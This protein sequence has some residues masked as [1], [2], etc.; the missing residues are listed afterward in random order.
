M[1]QQLPRKC[2]V[3]GN[4]TELTSMAILKWSQERNVKW[5][6][7]SPG[8]PQQNGFNESFKGRLRDECLNETLLTSPRHAR[9]V[10]S[11]WRLDYN[12]IRP[13][14]KLGGNTPAEFAAQHDLEHAPNHVAII[15][16][17]KRESAGF[18]S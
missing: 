10:L 2:I 9:M 13:H 8:K 12:S 3:S 18:Y 16:T 4:G 5:H 15:S 6:D 11:A 17:I 14:S 7:I 1:T